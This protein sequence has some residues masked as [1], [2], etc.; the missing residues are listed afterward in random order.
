M[1]TLPEDELLP[2]NQALAAGAVRVAALS[3]DDQTELDTGTLQPDRQ[4]DRSRPPP[5]CGSRRSFRTRS[6]TLW[7]GQFVNVRLLLQQQQGVVTVPSAAIQHGPDGLFAYVV[8][9]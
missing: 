9:S 2:V 1:F 6:N 8:Q 3:R 4:P 7:P 5:P